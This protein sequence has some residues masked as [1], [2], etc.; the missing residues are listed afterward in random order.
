MARELVT[1]IWCDV[2]LSPGEGQDPEYVK[3]EELPPVVLGNFKP[4]LLA[5]CEPHRKEFYDPFRDMVARL[6]Q[7]VPEG[8]ARPSAAPVHAPGAYACPVPTC[9]KH[10]N[11]YRHDTS[12]G[13]HCRREHG[14]TLTELREQYGTP[15][16]SAGDGGQGVL[17]HQ[18]GVL[19]GEPITEQK[20][21]NVTR[22]EC[23]V[24][25]DGEPCGKVYQWPENGRPVQALA[26]HKNRAHG[27]VAESGKAKAAK[28]AA[29]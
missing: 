12:L 11:P 28:A 8:A 23:D 5:L 27:I 15:A 21:P 9:P 4:R 16:G 22:T 13:S 1:H 3:G 29:K 7:V 10:A 2:C 17:L 18:D 20:P 6:G 26:V 14:A 25:V 19:G 24:L